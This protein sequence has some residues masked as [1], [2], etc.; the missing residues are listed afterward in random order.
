MFGGSALHRYEVE[1]LGGSAESVVEVH[2]VGV[3]DRN[4]VGTF[5]VSAAIPEPAPGLL[6]GLG[7][8]ALVLLSKKRCGSVR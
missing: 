4:G 5:V 8:A 2:N 6:V 3:F 7:V 1:L